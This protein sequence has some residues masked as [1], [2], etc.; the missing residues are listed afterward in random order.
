MKT[1]SKSGLKVQ[2]SVKAGALSGNHSRSGL[3]VRSAVKAG[4]LSGN[5]SR[6]GLRVRSA[7]KAGAPQRKPLPLRPR[8]FALPSRRAPRPRK[9]LPL[10]PRAFALPSRRAPL[11]AE[12][13]PAPVCAFAPP[14]RRAQASC[15]R[16][17]IVAFCGSRVK[18]RFQPRQLALWL[19]SQSS[20]CPAFGVSVAFAKTARASAAR[21]QARAW[22]RPESQSARARANFVWAISAGPTLL[23]SRIRRAR[24]STAT[25]SA[26]RDSPE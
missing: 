23:A 19:A 12:T 2:S 9:S 7:V 17:T 10:R 5:H 13:T 14:S 21:C 11:L 3:R 24:S 16:T 6:S 15:R 18:Q 25:A 1:I 26:G 22:S 8:A 20:T 4:A